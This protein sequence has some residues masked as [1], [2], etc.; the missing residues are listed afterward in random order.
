MSTNAIPSSSGSS[1][2]C[3]SLI[4][5]GSYN[6]PLQVT[7]V[8]VIF[9][10]SS[11]AALLPVL[12]TRFPRL[13]IPQRV[14]FI[15]KH[16]GTGVLIAT[17]FCHLLPTAF[18]SLLNPCLDPNS[19][20]GKYPAMAG[21]IAMGGLFVVVTVQLVFAELHGPENF[22][23]HRSAIVDGP[24]MTND[25]STTSTP[26]TANPVPEERKDER[27]ALAKAEEDGAF[28]RVAL[29]EMGILFHSVFIGMALSVS[30][31]SGF[32]ILFIAIVFHQTFEGLSLGT[33][34]SLLRFEP[35]G[36]SRKW[37]I[38]S[39]PARPYIMS[40]LY[41]LTTP[42]GQAI[43]LILLYSPHTSYDPASATALVLVGVM[44]AISAGLLL[45]ASLVELL[46]AD[47]LGSGRRSGLM[48]QSVRYRIYASLA[49]LGGAFSMALV[50]AW[51]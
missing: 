32:V 45:W 15:M 47:F 31:G 7:A 17:S 51:A 30:K 9:L 35:D 5:E 18:G 16:F 38:P 10:V 8:I 40:S 26:A 12:A 24:V 48:G 46:A 3:S 33:R 20:W 4:Q 34:I 22:H 44:N 43:G 19:V 21:A 39:P 41:G 13:R 50:G 6:K 29:L 36:V 42:L 1:S 14:L 11:S 25:G 23:H 27:L 49:V 2:A 28:L 37:Y